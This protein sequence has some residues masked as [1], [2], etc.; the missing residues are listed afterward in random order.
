M[1]IVL[2]IYIIRYTK[3]EYF[4]CSVSISV[5]Y[6]KALCFWRWLGGIYIYNF[7]VPYG[8]SGWVC[9]V[10]LSG[11]VCDLN[12]EKTVWCSQTSNHRYWALIMPSIIKYTT[13]IAPAILGG[14][15]ALDFYYLPNYL[16]VFTLHIPYLWCLR[17]CKCKMYRVIL[18]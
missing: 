18:L 12:C 10:C 11:S 6:N 3:I 7:K 2:C 13:R 1:L 14:R 4:A 15:R 17:Y 5:V 9:R 16:F 8:L